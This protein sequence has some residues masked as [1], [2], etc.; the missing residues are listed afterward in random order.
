MYQ[1]RDIVFPGLFILETK[2]P[3]ISYGDP[4][5][6]DVPSPH[7]PQI[8]Y[9]GLD[10]ETKARRKTLVGGSVRVQGMLRPC[11]HGTTITAGLTLL[12]LANWAG[13]RA[14]IRF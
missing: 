7:R 13:F 1:C 14:G 3:K 4:S 6:Q 8:S 5:F 12:A 11:G 9:T 10:I 2:G